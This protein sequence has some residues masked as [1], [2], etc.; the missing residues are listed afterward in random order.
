MG[1]T[2]FSCPKCKASFGHTSGITR[3]LYALG[4]PVIKCKS[5]GTLIHTGA[6]E[7]P[8]LRRG[9]KTSLWFQHRVL[10]PFVYS[11]IAAFIISILV[12]V[13]LGVTIGNIFSINKNIIFGLGC[14]VGIAT[15]VWFSITT[16]K[17]LSNGIAESKK[18]WLYANK[19]SREPNEPT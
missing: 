17:E 11:P 13:L 18:R 19:H 10:L 5:C 6:K 14:I 16:F 3:K 2:F 7:W 4:P 8:D 1:M 12:S 9:E 15:G